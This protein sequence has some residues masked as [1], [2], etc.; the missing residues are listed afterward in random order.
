MVDG[1][2]MCGGCRIITSG[3]AKFAC[4]DGPEFNA[5]TVD[6]DILA[7]RNRTYSD[8]EAEVLRDFHKHAHELVEEIRECCRLEAAHPEVRC[9]EVK[10]R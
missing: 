9:L 4:V 5:H 3:G 6:F 1:T 8:Q 7:R 10:I 2:G